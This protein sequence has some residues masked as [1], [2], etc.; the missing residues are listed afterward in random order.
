MVQGPLQGGLALCGVWSGV[1]PSGAWGAIEQVESFAG[2]E[3]EMP[4]RGEQPGG[5]REG[6]VVRVCVEVVL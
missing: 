4:T 1:W 5:F 2:R 6:F 3:D